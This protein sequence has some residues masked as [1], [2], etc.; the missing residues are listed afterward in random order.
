MSPFKRGLMLDA[1]PAQLLSARR[2][3]APG[4]GAEDESADDGCG[5]RFAIPVGP[6]HF[7]LFAP[8][9]LSTPVDT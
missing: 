3:E 7:Q 2:S 1:G 9:S 6:P 5:G 4:F 8:G